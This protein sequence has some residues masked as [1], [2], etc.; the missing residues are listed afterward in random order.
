MERA[1]FWPT[2]E[3]A[4]GGLNKSIYDAVCGKWIEMI[5]S[6]GESTGGYAIG[7]NSRSS[8]PLCSGCGRMVKK[9]FRQHRHDRPV[10]GLSL[11]RN[12]NAPISTLKPAIN[13]V[14][15]RLP[16]LAAGQFTARQWYR[17]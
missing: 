13:A 9:D 10:R 16:Q 3:V 15:Q 2:G 11:Q 7:V 14:F 17:N 8:S 5:Q 6:T 1:V 4:T 12:H